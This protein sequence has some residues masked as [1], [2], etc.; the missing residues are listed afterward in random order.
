MKLRFIIVSI[1]MVILNINTFSQTIVP[2][3]DVSGTWELA[4]SPYIIQGGITIPNDS[5]LVIEP[6]VKV[7][8]QGHYSLTVMGRLLAIG[9]E[10][11]SIL[12]TINDTIGFSNPDTTLGGWYGIRFTDTPLTNDSS[13]LVHCCLEYGKAFGPVW[14]LNAGGAICILQYGKV[15]ISNCLIRNN[16]ALSPTDQLPIGGGLYLF[17]SHVIIR[18]NTFLNNRAHS[19]GAIFFD[20]SDPVFTD[21]IIKN[22][23][24]FDGAAISMG[25]EC[26]PSFTKDKILNNTAENHGGGM[27][28]SEPSVVTC[29]QIAVSGNKA[30]WGGGIGTGRGELIANN[31]QFVENQAENWGGGVAGDYA[32]L[33]LSNCTFERNRSDWGSGGLHIDHASADIMNCD[34]IENSAVIGGGFHAVYSQ[35]ISEQNN[36]LH[37]VTEAGGAIHL[38]NSDCVIDQC[39]FEGNQALKGTGGAI[40]YSADSTVFG[41]KYRLTVSR[42]SMTENSAYLHS[43]AARIEQTKSDFSL[44]DVVLDSCQ[45]IRNHADVY[46]SLRIGGHMEDFTVAN[47]IFSGNTSDRYVGSAGFISNSRGSVFNCVFNSNYSV[48]SDSSKTAHGASLGSGA[49]VEFLNCTFVDTSSTSGVGLSV[50]R[51][52][53]A[54]ITNTVFWACGERPVSIVTAAGLGCIANINYCNIENGPDSI[55]VSDSLSVLNWGI[56]NLAED[57]LFVD[58]QNSDLHLMD[59]SPCIGAGINIFSINDKWIYAPTRDIEGNPR[60]GPLD[61]KADMGAYEN[62]LGTPVTA[63]FDS[64]KTPGETAVLYQNYPN[65]FSG[66]TTFTYLLF[67]P[68]EVELNIYNIYGQRITTL[69]SEDQT[70]GLYRV[71]WEGSKY[72]GGQY[73]Y[74]LKTDRG[75]VKSGKLLM[76]K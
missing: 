70:A 73:F 11:D 49:E 68:C 37:N 75:A 45:F 39:R 19:G 63:G 59:S 53:K 18:D 38:E 44:V 74:R 21:N 66:S 54:D 3:G 58:L 69:V 47:C 26:H 28:F 76:I 27:S 9:T 15:L 72:A 52:C 5:T 7:E 64:F 51:G 12:F 2:G 24:A 20:E 36:F 67:N 10:T 40:D 43:G 35:V 65:P 42:S 55:F 29:N 30:V 71:E 60:P 50:R 62:A 23:F 1:L 13:K 32:T 31:C 4:N 34:F 61:S 57:P 6:G 41:R 22:N 56:G 46:G 25:G 14:H 17:K 8:F 33:H 16:S 48:Y